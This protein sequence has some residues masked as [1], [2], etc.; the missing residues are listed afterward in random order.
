MEDSVDD[1]YFIRKGDNVKIGRAKDPANRLKALQTGCPEKLELAEVLDGR[2]Y[3]ERVWHKAFA[4]E[5]LHGEWFL[6]SRQLSKAISLAARGRRW[7]DHLFPPLDVPLSDDEFEAEDDIV[8][9]HIAV[10]VA[11]A[12]AAERAGLPTSFAGRAF[13]AQDNGDN[14]HRP[15]RY[16][17]PE[18]A[19]RYAR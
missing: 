2:G 3:E 11:L 8:D 15:S 17:L 18:E 6:M 12:G 1:L 9:W 4:N 19:I 16:K 7:W 10:H 5:R 13:Y 14:V